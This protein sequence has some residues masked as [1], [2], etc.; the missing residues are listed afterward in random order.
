MRWSS[1]NIFPWLFIILA[2]LISG[3]VKTTTVNLMAGA[4]SKESGAAVFSGD[5]DPGLVGDAM[6]FAIKLYESLVASSPNNRPLLLATGKSLCMYAYAF[7]QVPAEQLTYTDLDTKNEMLQRAKRL[8]LRGRDYILRAITLRHPHFMEY[9]DKNDFADAFH[10]ISARDTSYLYWLGMAWMA[11]FTAD[12]GDVSLMVD[13]PKAVALANKVLELNDGYSE[14]AAH[15]FFITY[16]GAMPAAMGGSEEK[17]REHFNKAVAYSKGCKS[18]PYI[19]LAT[20]VCVKNQNLAEFKSLVET[21][22]KVDVNKCP[23][24]R[25]LNILNIQKA[26]WLLDHTDA[27]FLPAEGDTTK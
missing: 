4:L 13:I 1:K 20:T 22:L 7:V 19:A 12:K 9:L 14:G 2:L 5:D 11:A 26:H 6:P 23:G 27:F 3:C 21:A 18:S 16:Y 10:G 24:N 25:L 8:Y 17:A 15:E